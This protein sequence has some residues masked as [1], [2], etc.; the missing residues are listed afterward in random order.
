MSDLTAFPMDS[1][2][3]EIGDDGLP[4]YDRAFDSTDLRE[5]YKT[6]FSNGYFAD[7][8]T[9]MHVIAASG[10]TATVEAGKV[11]I[12]GTLGFMTEDATVSFAAAG[13]SDRIDTVV[14]RLDL[15]V[16]KRCIE[17]DVL[18]GTEGS[19]AAP[20]LTR[21][22]TVWELGLANVKIPASSS[23]VIAAN[24]TDTRL[25]TDRCGVVEPFA[26]LDTASLFDQVTAI[27][28]KAGEDAD[29]LV[30]DTKAQLDAEVE[31]AS[32]EI[33][34]DIGKLTRATNDAVSAM[35]DALSST[36]LGSVWR[37]QSSSSAD[38]LAYGDDLN[39]IASVCSKFCESS[40]V[41][42]GILNKPSEVTGAFALYTF[43]TETDP[44][45][46]GQMLLTVD[47]S[48][49]SQFFRSGAGS[50]WTAWSAIGGGTVKRIGGTMGTTSAKTLGA[51]T[52]AGQYWL[53]D[54]T[55]YS[56]RPVPNSTDDTKGI[57]YL[58]GAFALTVERFDN[59]SKAIVQR[60][61]M[62]GA[63]AHAAAPVVDCK[64][65]SAD[66]GS[67]WSR[68]QYTAQPINVGWG[69]YGNN[70]ALFPD[71]LTVYDQMDN[72]ASISLNGTATTFDVPGVWEGIE[73]LR[74]SPTCYGIA[75]VNAPSSYELSAAFF[76]CQYETDT[77]LRLVDV[78]SNFRVTINSD[79]TVV[80]Q[81]L[82]GDQYGVM[83]LH[84]FTTNQYINQRNYEGTIHNSSTG[85]AD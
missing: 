65:I 7:V 32:G 36:V 17:L 85:R 33:E 79:D 14:A 57:G 23:S 48:G 2:V 69:K 10:M 12:Q 18:K 56:D 9:S 5:V 30:A 39:N 77:S 6:Y 4:V 37:L 70:D 25:D 71:L 41:A 44:T 24:I 29:Q 75:T 80:T 15:S 22:S 53:S 19:T 11:N 28:V 40:S 73:K 13:T 58:T 51:I 81:S 50:S 64:R 35:N 38:Y 82:I 49:V 78:T 76:Y 72:N 20:T 83:T 43:A 74:R 63:P 42:G 68:W 21:D 62:F 46:L 47:S 52:T 84:L 16:D 61:E 34:A 3:T 8:G 66:G 59:N 55:A 54:I 27:I 45:R 26:K 31:Q 60:L 67:T 1:Q